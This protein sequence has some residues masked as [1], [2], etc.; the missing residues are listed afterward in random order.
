MTSTS[1]DT[2]LVGNKN[3]AVSMSPSRTPT[4]S[5]VSDEVA[6][7]T[8]GWVND[9]VFTPLHPVTLKSFMDTPVRSWVN[10]FTDVEGERYSNLKCLM[11]SGRILPGLVPNVK[12]FDNN[13]GAQRRIA[14]WEDGRRSFRVENVVEPYG[15]V[16]YTHLTLPTKRIV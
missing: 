14:V 11:P 6:L 10:D 15:A 9:G 2:T 7:P 13:W 8:L 1:V 5:N 16:S 12:E 4:S 3:P